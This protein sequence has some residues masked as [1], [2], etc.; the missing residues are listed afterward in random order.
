MNTIGLAAWVA[1]MFGFGLLVAG[2]SLVSVPA[3]LVVAGLLLMFWAFLADRA[4]AR[5]VLTPSAKE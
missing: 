4:A 5:V 1:G 2:V 3:G